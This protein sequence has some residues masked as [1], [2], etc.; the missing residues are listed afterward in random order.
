MCLVWP[1]RPFFFFL[2]GGG[3]DDREILET[4]EMEFSSEKE[5]KPRDKASVKVSCTIAH[6][7]L[8]LVLLAV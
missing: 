8:A 5:K 7:T 6:N 2:G 1:S 4:Y 3:Q